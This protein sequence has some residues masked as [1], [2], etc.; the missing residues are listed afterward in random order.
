M[1]WRIRLKTLV[2]CLAVALALQP[3][4][5]RACAACYGQS[6]SPM[7]AGMNWGIMSLLAV[8]AVVLG[9]VGAFFIYLARRS[10][11]TPLLASMGPTWPVDPS[12]PIVGHSDTH[13]HLGI[14]TSQRVG[15]VE[16][17]CA[18]ER[19]HSDTVVFSDGRRQIVP[20]PTHPTL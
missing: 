1:S 4:S 18:R 9:G 8:I 15:Q 2:T 10:A 17:R 14:A 12:V 7:A 16:H 3:N 19:A 5:L 6:D 13:K 20:G 11:K